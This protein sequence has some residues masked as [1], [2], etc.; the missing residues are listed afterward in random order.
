MAPPDEPPP[1]V[2]HP[3]SPF[4][5]ESTMSQPSLF[6][7]LSLIR[8][9]AAFRAVFFARLL[10]LVSLG[11][12]GIAIAVQV[13]ALTQ[14]PWKVGLA[15]SLAGVGMFVGLMLGG[16]L[17]DRY[18]RRRLILLARATCGLGF[19][20]LWLNAL[21]PAPSLLAIYGLALWDG[22]FG[23]LGVTALLAATP[24]LVGRENLVKA[25]A[26]SQ[27]SVRLGSIASPVL[28]GW[29]IASAGVAWNYAL[30]ALGTL[31]TVLLLLRLP[32]LPAPPSRKETPWA[33]LAGGVAFVWRTPLVGGVALLG[34][35]LSMASAVRVLYPALA[36]SWQMSPSQLGWLYAATPIG[37]AI[38][39]LTS[40]RLGH[41]A[42]PG[43]WLLGTALGAFASLALFVALPAGWLMWPCLMLFGYL[44][45]LNGLLQYALI[46]HFTPDPLLGR[47]N[48][49]WT[50][51]TVSGDALG[52]ALLGGLGA[53]LAPVAAVS[54]FGVTAAGL[55]A[56]LALG[57]T[58]LREARFGAAEPQDQGLAK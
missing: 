34:S 32:A 27:L 24:A 16:V 50:A 20:G 54:L 31:F 56:G 8:T 7:D 48:G 5:A 45:A 47:V 41:T 2:V 37:A 57:R 6:I 21:L 15:V 33:A 26:I 10:S 13:Q 55:G 22:F 44:S 12:L 36:D 35:L 40:G 30:A 18:E 46:Q 1:R 9:H 14:S 58:R 53:L 49:L 17:A 29:L 42:R 4:I 39:A 38:G 52:A 11:L 3:V 23:A 43:V 19:V 28:G 25:G 51:Q